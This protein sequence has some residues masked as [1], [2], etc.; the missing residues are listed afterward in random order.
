MAGEIATWH[1][2]AVSAAK[3]HNHCQVFVPSYFAGVAQVLTLADVSLMREDMKT[4]GE[5]ASHST[6]GLDTTVVSH[7][8]RH[9]QSFQKS[10][11]KKTN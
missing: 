10:L 1:C 2:I 4:C 7:S 8:H 3:P 6:A 11:I 5:S 9:F